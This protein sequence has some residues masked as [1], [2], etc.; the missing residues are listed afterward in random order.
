LVDEGTRQPT[1][2]VIGSDYISSSTAGQ[3]QD[4][5]FPDTVTYVAGATYRLWIHAVP[6][7]RR[8]VNTL[9]STDNGTNF[10]SSSAT[11]PAVNGGSGTGWYS[12]DITSFITSQGTLND[13]RVRLSASS[14]A[15]GGATASQVNVVYIEQS[16]SINTETSRDLRITGL[17][18]NLRSAV[19]TWA[20]LQYGGGVT[21]QVSED[22]RDIRI[23]GEIPGR[24]AV[25]T[26]A[27]MAT[28]AGADPK[29]GR[30]T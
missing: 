7:S 30:I 28:G 25:V 10:A 8:G 19:V 12:R 27:E 22:S 21:A 14:I 18:A 16:I 26:W 15:G 3:L 2:P 5:A 13:L 4:L 23:F 1:V 20:E 11:I 6:G 29:R 24:Q 17:A 9:I